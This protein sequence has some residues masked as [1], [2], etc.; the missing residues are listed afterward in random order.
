MNIRTKIILVVLPLLIATLLINGIV[1]GLSAGNGLTRIAMRFL[2]YKAEQLNE[3]LNTQ[4]ELLV[5]NALASDPV[6]LEVAKNSALSFASKTIKSETE[7]I[8]AFDPE[9]RIVLSTASVAPSAEEKDAVKVMQQEGRSGWL[10]YTMGGQERVGHAFAFKPFGWYIVVSEAR[11]AFF[12]EVRAITMQSGAILAV[13]VVLALVLLV[14]FSSYLT[15]PLQRL[16]GAMDHVIRT[17]DFSRRVVVEYADEIGGVAHEFNVMNTQLEKSYARI[18]EFALKEALA[19]KQ[20]VQREYETLNVLGKAAEYKDPETGAHIVR[21]GYYARML[22]RLLNE[23]E[24][25]Q[26][27]IYYAAPLHDI[28]K[29]GIPDSI[30]LKPARLDRREMNLMKT[31]AVLGH[32][33]LRHAQSPYLQAGATIALTHHERYDGTGYPGG[34]AGSGIPLYGRIVCLIDVFDALTSKRPYKDAWAF[35]R[36]VDLLRQQQGTYFDPIVVELF[37][38]SMDT[39]RRI[40]NENQ[41][42]D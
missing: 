32:E 29:I 26:D 12:R 18:K 15:R 13:S 7:R 20:V 2:G 16:V 22:A 3:Y 28:G 5:S 17:N 24:V 8:V 40:F 27:L 38:A 9:G 1:S 19:R 6:Y 34:L 30:L 10:E 21:V 33:I 11:T 35:D 37:L 4:W 23:D 42:E 14:A 31:H 39:V 25:S 41:E 36:A